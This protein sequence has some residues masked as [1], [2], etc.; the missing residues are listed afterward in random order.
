MRTTSATRAQ[1]QRSVEYPAAI[2]PRFNISTSSCC[3]SSDNL[4]AGPGCGLAA[5]AATPP[6]IQARFQRF[7][8]ERLAP[9]MRATSARGFRSLKSFAA[10]RRRASGASQ[11]LGSIAAQGSIIQSAGFTAH[12][13]L[14]LLM[15]RRYNR[16]S[17]RANCRRWGQVNRATRLPRREQLYS[18]FALD[19]E[20][21]CFG[22]SVHF[23]RSASST[24]RSSV[25]P[26]IGSAKY[27]DC[28][29]ARGGLT[30]IGAPHW[31]L[32]VAA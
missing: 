4:G 2:G 26:M 6:S 20:T 23:T 30:S 15:G 29:I 12:T 18:N 16:S 32:Q 7:T 24:V 14:P 11:L 13:A 10:R 3:W 5:K 19:S 8:L 25:E 28:G 22:K 1:V 31:L 9:T 21:T 27:S 17:T